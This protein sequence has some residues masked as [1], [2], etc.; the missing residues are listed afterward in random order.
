MRKRLEITITGLVQGVGFRPF[1]ARLASE[2][3]LAGQVAN[4][5]AGLELVLEGPAPQLKQFVARLKAEKPAFSHFET[6]KI[7][8]LSAKGLEDFTIAQ[9]QQSGPVLGW[10]LPDL[11]PCNKCLK[12]LND[13]QDRRFGYPFLN[14]TECGPRYS[15]VHRLPYDR[16]QTTMAG[17]PLCPLC[18][19]EYKDPQNR[20][21]H[22][23][24][25]ACPTCG[26]QLSFNSPVSEAQ[27][28]PALEAAKRLLNAGGVLA[29]KGVG[30]YLLSCRADLEAPLKKLRQKKNRQ[31]KP[32]ALLLKDL[33]ATRQLAEVSEIEAQLLTSP[34]APIVLLKAK[35]SPQ[36]LIA[37][38]CPYLGIMLPS[39]PLHYLLLDQYPLVATSGNL[40]G[41]PLCITED[42]AFERL[43]E[44]ADGFLTH[45]RPILRGIDDSVV[46]LVGDQPQFLRRARGYAPLPLSLS[47]PLPATLGLGGD[48]KSCLAL[49]RGAQVFLSQ[50][51]GD[52]DLP[53]AQAGYLKHLA[54]FQQLFEVEVTQSFGDLHPRYRSLDLARGQGFLPRFFQHHAAHAYALRAE[55]QTMGEALAI[56]ADG[57]GYGPDGQ[58][59]GCELFLTKEKNYH[60]LAHLASFPLLGGDIA[61][62]E[63]GRIAFSLLNQALGPEVALQWAQEI[64]QKSPTE[65][66]IW[67]QMAQTGLNSPKCRSLGR[68]FDGVSA[69]LGLGLE[70][71][72]EAQAAMALEWALE[73]D[74]AQ[75]E[76][77]PMTDWDWFLMIKQL[78]RDHQGGRPR[79]QIAAAFHNGL[80]KAMLESAQKTGVNQV[81][82]TGGCFQN[83]YLQNQVVLALKSQGFNPIVHRLLPPNDA[84]LGL[85]QLWMGTQQITED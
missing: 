3:G 15:V 56:V 67:L 41:E 52:L 37:P 5:P 12:E 10:V 43:G 65:G 62:K 55:A 30:G 82:L 81:L 73:P 50:H 74:A 16:A 78:W 49:S 2:L 17:F 28:P 19:A 57:T 42:E 18:L 70:V 8:E 63:P 71:E 7:V 40:S 75:I 11:A 54:D 26:P 85:G 20:R 77:Y 53:L 38:G 21:Y 84:N 72:Y 9:S 76:P 66:Q 83:R 64:L 59:W 4:N 39:S 1:V 58:I 45:N 48:I 24:P 25:T 33:E 61:T 29:W 35:S 27:G 51:L 60:P 22:A 36:P 47:Q 44:L 13:P 23:Q 31:F 79:A 34:Q 80:V 32:F 6:C 46:Q 69:L 14:C 68:L